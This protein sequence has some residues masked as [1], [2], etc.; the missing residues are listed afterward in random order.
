MISRGEQLPELKT[1]L[2]REFWEDGTDQVEI[3]IHEQQQCRHSSGR[4]DG[5]SSSGLS[6]E[7]YQVRAR[8]VSDVKSAGKVPTALSLVGNSWV[9]RRGLAPSRVPGYAAMRWDRIPF[10]CGVSWLG[11][12]ALHLGV[13]SGDDEKDLIHNDQPRSGPGIWR[14]QIGKDMTRRRCVRPFES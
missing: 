13:Q 12:R 9:I 4:I 8:Q 11:G 7:A 1:L 2:A 5:G 10:Q 3:A 6:E 14:G